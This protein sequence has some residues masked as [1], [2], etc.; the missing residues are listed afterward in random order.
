VVVS[1]VVLGLVAPSSISGA[2]E[3]ASSP[4][5]VLVTNDDGVRAPG[6]DVLVEAL[7]KV[8]GVAVTVVAPAENQSGAS[9]HANPDPSSVTSSKTTTSSGYPAIAVD[10]YP[11]DSVVW[12]LDGGVKQ[13]PDLVVSGINSV[14]NLGVSVPL[15][16]TVGA[17]RTAA[18][19]GIRALA[20]SQGGGNPPDYPAGAS[21][22]VDWLRQ[23]RKELFAQ[24]GA[25]PTAIVGV[26]N[27]NVPTC[28]TGRVR[29]VVRV[30]LATTGQSAPDCSS[31]LTDPKTDAE[32]FANGFA[33]LT[34][35]QSSAVCSRMSAATGPAP[36]LQDPVLT[37]VSGVA[38]SQ[39]H[40]PV[41]WVHNDSGGEPAAYAISPQG[42]AL[43]AYPVEG[44][45]ATD[46]E[47]IA[48]GPGPK[49]GTS[50]L[51]LADIGDNGSSRDHI[52]VYRVPEPTA[53]PS[54]AGV[55]LTGTETFSLRYPGG[56]VDAEALLV[57]PESG[58][59]FVID[60]EYTSGVGRVFR[61]AKSQLADG[62]DATMEEVASFTMSPDDEKFGS[63]LPGTIITGAD[64][65]PDGS[66]V[67]VRTYRRVL[68]FARPKGAPLADA[69]AIDPCPAPQASEPQGEAV[70]FAANGRAYYTISEGEHAPINRFT[71]R[72][73]SSR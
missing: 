5:R 70:G 59:L 66:I 41:L 64:V 13:R 63:G 54:G 20:V 58:D 45:T 6:I 18:R 53:V 3:S 36:T 61:V 22:A 51:Y 60:K 2:A 23:H 31:T 44:A 4:L 21:L 69:F 27:L 72:Y 65:S 8:P 55:T 57:D 46:W 49:R 19:R 67:L 40:P 24:R 16:G 10:G 50:Y 11:A 43:G 42:A 39:L 56:A 48:V 30:P 38:A 28:T 62:A 14:E 52:T 1:V 71:V 37:E 26:D 25:K 15:S 17:A 7:R 9:D 68:A 33:S 34:E 12:A 32:A 29:G 35:M 73:T 47:D